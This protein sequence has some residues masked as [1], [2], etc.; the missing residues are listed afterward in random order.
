MLSSIEDNKNRN[1]QVTAK[2][3]KTHT[4]FRQFSKLL[5]YVLGR[6]PFEFG[7]V[8]DE[9]GFV[10]M[11]T[12]LKAI[13]E[14]DGWKHIRAVHFQEI[15]LREIDPPVECAGNRIRSVDRIHLPE[16]K[17]ATDLPKLLYVCVR[18]KAHAHVFENGISPSAYSRVVLSADREMAFRIGKRY[19]SKAVLLTVNCEKCKG[20]GILIH[21]VGGTLYTTGH[22]PPECFTGP[23]PE[24]EPRTPA[25]DPVVPQP[26][27]PGSFILDIQKERPFSAKI[28]GRKKEIPWKKDRKR[29]KKAWITHE[30]N[31]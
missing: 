18:Q 29:L 16:Q 2:Y 6:R 22:I 15:L 24:H 21:H 14:E 20:R 17:I 12:L 9:N 28:K 19:D 7:L 23:A 1:Y 27:T 13:H 26:N 5:S 10:S 8:L 30:T 25:P 31:N 4:T 11:Q 3:M